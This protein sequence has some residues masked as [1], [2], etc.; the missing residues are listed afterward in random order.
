[1]LFAYVSYI[2]SEIMGYSGIMTLFC[3]GLAMSH[4]AYN[5]LSNKSKIGSVLAIETIGHAAEAFLFTYLGLCIYGVEK[6]KISYSF[7]VL[8][9]LSC[10]IARAA[11]VFIPSLFLGLCSRFNT[12]LSLREL[13][14]I[15]FSGIIR[16]AIAFA[17]SL[18]VNPKLSPQASLLI[19][20]TLVVVLVT[21]LLFGGLMS[22]FSKFLG[23]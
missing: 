13:T 3:C 4:Y 18:Q 5:N 19:S 9:L 14:L 7:V 12:R 8:L 6:N 21:S 11:A 20:S 17:L 10:I 15:W 2:S 1:M 16:G 23:I 22:V